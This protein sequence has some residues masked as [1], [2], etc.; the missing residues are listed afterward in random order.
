[1]RV[2]HAGVEGAPGGRSAPTGDEH[3]CRGA[4][5]VCGE[6]WTEARAMGGGLMTLLDVDEARCHSERYE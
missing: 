5:I 6:Q 4:H 2:A 1:M 3:S